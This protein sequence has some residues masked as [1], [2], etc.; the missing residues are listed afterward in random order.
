MEAP[1]TARCDTVRVAQWTV[2]FNLSN[3][4][5]GL[6]QGWDVF[7]GLQGILNE[8]VPQFK[9]VS[10]VKSDHLAR[11]AKQLKIGFFRFRLG[12]VFRVGFG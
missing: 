10:F 7:D 4:L 8:V 9:V 3:T 2:D 6:S 5:G 11:Q 12:S 1:S